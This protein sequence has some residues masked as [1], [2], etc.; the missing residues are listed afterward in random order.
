MAAAPAKNDAAADVAQE[1]PT[2]SNANPEV[3]RLDSDVSKPSTVAPG[4]A[5][6]DTT[7]PA[8]RAS[9][10]G[11][12]KMAAALAGFGTVNAVVPIPAPE[13]MPG[14]EPGEH[15]IEEYPA[16]RPDGSLVTVEHNIDTGETRIK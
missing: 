16:R 1:V 10:V 14:E 11:G 15:R 3:T 13:P 7:D 12:D 5:P 2:D 4:D 6:H 9:T 8:E